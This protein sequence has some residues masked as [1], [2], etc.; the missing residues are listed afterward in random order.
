MLTVWIGSRF[1][2]RSRGKGGDAMSAR[3]AKLTRAL[4]ESLKPEEKEFTTWD[5][6][7]KRLGL[8]VLP[9]GSKIYVL[10]L[11][12]DGRQRWVTIGH[13][14]DPWMPET[15]RREAERLLGLKAEGKDVTLVRERAKQLPN[16]EEFA[17][18]FMKE[19]AA[20][21]LKESSQEVYRF[22]VDNHIIPALG[23]RRIDQVVRADVES[24]HLK[25]K[26]KPTAANRV[27]SLIHNMMDRAEAWALR[28]LNSNPAQGIRYFKERKRTRSLSPE[29]FAKLGKVLA[30]LE[31]KESP[32][33]LAAFRL[34]ML[35]GCR[36]SEIFRLRWDEVDFEH[37]AL[38]LKDSKT[39]ATAPIYISVFSISPAGAAQP[40]VGSPAV[41]DLVFSQAG[42]SE[43]PI[44]SLALSPSSA[45][46]NGGQMTLTI[47][48][49]NGFDGPSAVQLVF[50][51]NNADTAILG[52]NYSVTD[53]NGNQLS[54]GNST[55]FIDALTTTVTITG[56]DDHVF[57]PNLT[58]TIATG[59]ITDGLVSASAGS[60]TGTIINVDTATVTLT[61]S[62]PFFNENGGQATV[63]ATLP[64]V[65]RQNTTIDLGF[66]G[67]ALANQD[68]K[69]A[70]P[71]TFPGNSPVQ[72]VI[73]A[74]QLTGSIVLTGASNPLAT[75]GE[76]VV[77]S[78]ATINGSP[79]VI[80]VSI[81]LSIASQT[82]PQ[83]SIEN[84]TFVETG[85][86]GVAV[87]VVRLS[88]ASSNTVTVKY[89]TADGTAAAGTDYTAI[90]NAPLSFAP[91]TTEQTISIPILAEP[92]GSTGSK[93][94]TVTLTS[95]T[96]GTLTPPSATSESATV[97]LVE[98]NPEIS[99]ED[100]SIVD[101]SPGTVNVDVQL[102]QAQTVTVTVPYQ[103]TGGT[104]MA[105]TNY[106][107]K[108]G[109]VTFP[110]GQTLETI[111]I[112]IL[113][114]T[115]QTQSEFFNVQLSNP[116]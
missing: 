107:P 51:P 14:G 26:D 83:I 108:N 8:R 58:F 15:A 78:A 102:S 97:T 59:R 75:G 19:Y 25:L 88:A 72:I 34:L 77:V 42:G 13:D 100:T 29:E 113:G 23:K 10:R 40:I 18:R 65:A 1:L 84:Q 112:P 5:S 80:P 89:S 63:T 115:N 11:R 24:L 66:G 93:T 96:N 86:A 103:T 71:G 74:G 104:A 81:T 44:I 53:A 4:V 47:S 91:G 94:F 76:T 69:I 61:A 73:P 110:A 101:T 22:N 111:S 9:S 41:A 105:G 85:A 114:D 46:E 30:E 95:P 27:L 37:G 82:P 12:Q 56:I 52:T 17:N 43:L 3:R 109:T 54:N 38:N 2:F 49:T 62:P 7:M 33:V 48:R 32:F 64:F 106:I 6:E 35:T 98:D 67:S 116:S 21:H 90:S 45:P 28:P 39:G 60:V 57:T 16:L 70:N 20:A 36:C 87:V 68:Y 99:I 55:V 79:P 92:P 31:G 50:N